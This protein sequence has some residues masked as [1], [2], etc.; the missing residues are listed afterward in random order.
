MWN[1]VVDLRD[2]YRSNLGPN[3]ESLIGQRIRQI[4]DNTSQQRILGLGYATPYLSLFEE[5]SERVIAAM[6]ARQGVLHWPVEGTGKVT[7]CEEA[8]IPLPDVSVDRVLMVHALE[9][10]EQLRPMLR[11]V[12]RVL[13]DGGRLIAVVPNRRGIWARMDRTPFGHGYPYTPAQLNRLLRDT[14]FTPIQTERALYMPP[15]QSRVM[16]ASSRAWEEVG[17]RLFPT[18]S[19]VL[20]VEAGKQIYAASADSAKAPRRRRYTAPVPGAHRSNQE[21]TPG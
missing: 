8:E 9:C 2:F 12:W 18:F 13:A 16:L 19:G 5:E 21:T 4:W 3:A 14:L 1:D 17:S 11:E 6:P 7:L 15:S 20:I 10:S